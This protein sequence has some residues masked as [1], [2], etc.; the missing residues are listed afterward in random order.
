MRLPTAATDPATQLMQLRQPEPFGVLYHHDRRVGDVDADLD[1]RGGNQHAD[2]AVAER[3][4]HPVTL[5]SLDPAVD[6]ADHH[7]IPLRLQTGGHGLRSAQVGALTLLDHRQDDVRLFT[8]KNLLV[9]EV[10]H[11]PTGA[12]R[13]HRTAYLAPSGWTLLEHRDIQVTIARERQ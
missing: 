2:L 10:E 11:S 3:A 13:A 9:D 12:R 7:V 8:G 6:Q 5:R 4:H 1:H